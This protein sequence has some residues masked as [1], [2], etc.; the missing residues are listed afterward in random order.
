[1]HDVSLRDGEQQAGL[2]FSCDEKIRIAEKRAE[3]G[4]QRIE[5]GM[6]AVSKQDEKATKEIVKR[7]LGSEIFAFGRCMIDDVKRAV[8]CGVKGIVIE[9]PSSEHIIE[10]HPYPEP[11]LKLRIRTWQCTPA[12]IPGR[13]RQSFQL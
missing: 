2:V 7:N 10:N 5:A 11:E 6:P 13:L 9:I 4:V 3:V 1:V 12:G 8:D